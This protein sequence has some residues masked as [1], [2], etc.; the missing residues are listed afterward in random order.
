MYQLAVHLFDL[1]SS[2]SVTEF[3]LRR[4]TEENHLNSSV[5]AKTAIQQHLYVNDLLFSVPSCEMAV[6]LL[7]EINDLLSSGGF[8]LAKQSSN[9]REVLGAISPE[10]LA[11]HLDKVDLYEN[12]L[13]CS[14]NSWFG[15]SRE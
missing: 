15:V 14:Q 6:R 2:S 13:P 12:A 1:T 5:E 9:R 11:P 7:S 4:T 10:L 8:Q 3:A